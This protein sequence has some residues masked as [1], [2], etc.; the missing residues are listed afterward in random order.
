MKKFCL[1]LS[2]ILCL[3]VLAFAQDTKLK[4]L[5][6]PLP[7]LPQNHSTSNIQGTVVL[8]VQFNDFGEIGEIT[9]VQSLPPVVMEKAVAA[10]RKIKFQP[11]QKDGKPVS[12]YKDITYFYSWNGGWRLP[13]DNTAPVTPPKAEPGKAEEILQK[14]INLLGGSNYLQIKSQIGRGKFSVIKEGAVASFQTFTDVLIFPDKERTEFKGSGSKTV[15]VNTGETGWVY[16]GE[17]DLIRVQN[18][19][20]I[21]NFKQGIQTSLDNLLRGYWKGS[22]DLTYVGKRPASLGKRNDVVRLTYKDGFSIEFEFA[23]DDG[24]PQKA[25]YKT[26]SSDGEELTE[27]DRYAQFLDINGVKSPFV[28]DRVVGGKPSSRINYETLEFNKPIPDSIFVKPASTK[29]LKKDLKW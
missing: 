26:R 21:A 10:A 17:Q 23:A 20:Q 8:H 25:I 16:D 5:D 9:P 11:E 15:Q 28:I 4:I 22:A 19:G 27:E 18:A 1:I 2:F 13:T 7:D 24:L 12:V 29:E 14:A 6:Q 3:G